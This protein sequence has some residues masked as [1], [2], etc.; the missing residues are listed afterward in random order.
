MLF[1][2]IYIVVFGAE[3]EDEWDKSRSR[4]LF[5]DIILLWKRVAYRYFYPPRSIFDDGRFSELLECLFLC[6]AFQNRN[7]TVQ[8]F[9]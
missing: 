8:K 5:S 1:A 7:E 4:S 3:L 6:S 2:R 9:A